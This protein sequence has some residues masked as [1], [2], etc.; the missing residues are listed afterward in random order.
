MAGRSLNS[1]IS[2]FILLYLL[3]ISFIFC[4]AIFTRDGAAFL[5]VGILSL[6][7]LILLLAR[8]RF[9]DSAHKQKRN[10]LANWLRD[11]SSILLDPSAGVVDFDVAFE[12]E[13]FEFIATGYPSPRLRAMG[14]LLLR[15]EPLFSGE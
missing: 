11:V 5:L 13:A 10:V 8:S 3:F 7:G 4:Y 9:R 12:P 1:F 6:L 14:R 2:Y 15:A